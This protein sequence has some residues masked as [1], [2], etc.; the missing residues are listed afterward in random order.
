MEERGLE[1]SERPVRGD[2]REIT[3]TGRGTPGW[4]GWVCAGAGSSSR[5][6]AVAQAV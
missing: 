1:T 2:R 3:G 5:P 6:Q 4:G